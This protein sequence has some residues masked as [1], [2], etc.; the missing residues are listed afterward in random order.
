MVHWMAHLMARSLGSVL[1]T[2]ARSGSFSAGS[3]RACSPFEYEICTT[4]S[5]LLLVVGLLPLPWLLLLP[6]R[7]FPDGPAPRRPAVRR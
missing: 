3:A 2:R 5:L 6:P 1:S 4:A 7:R